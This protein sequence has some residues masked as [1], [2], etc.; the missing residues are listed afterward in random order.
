MS[1]YQGDA[2]QSLSHHSNSLHAGNTLVPN[3]DVVLRCSFL[4]QPHLFETLAL[5]VSCHC[6]CELHFH[7]RTGPQMSKKTL[8][9]TTNNHT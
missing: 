3:P 2:G 7:R 6:Q 8:V 5:D 1:L 9:K 4:L